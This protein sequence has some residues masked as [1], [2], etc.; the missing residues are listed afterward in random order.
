MQLKKLLC[1]VIILPVC[2]AAQ[3][4]I[5]ADKPQTISQK[6]PIAEQVVL[7][8]VTKTVKDTLV[9]A[10]KQEKTA[11][12]SVKLAM[13]EVNHVIAPVK[14]VAEALFK[15]VPLV[16]ELEYY[17]KNHTQMLEYT[18]NYMRNFSNR[19]NNINRPEKGGRYFAI[20]D[21][22]LEKNSIPKE[23]KY[24]A[25]IE[26][27]LNN[28]AVSPVG[29][30]GPWQFMASTGRLMGLRI[31][32][33]HDERRD[34]AKS[35]Q[36]A[37]KYLTYLYDQLDDW[38]LVVAAYNSG[39]RPVINAINRTGK[40]DYWS[41][42]PYLPKETQNHVLAFI[43]TATIMERLNQYL[44]A[45]LPENFNWTSL[46]VAK[47]KGAVASSTPTNPLLAKFGENELK[48]MALVRIKTP[49]DLDLL[50]N[51]LELDRR[52]LGRWN[53]DYYDYLDT[54]Q[55]GA[56]Y[57]LKIPKEKLDS[58]IEKREILERQSAKL[59]M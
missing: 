9:V 18:K 20:I 29:A 6:S 23:L 48:K 32:G 30:V 17:G 50:A 19:L 22:I 27:A 14:A 24:L 38:L 11:P 36:A 31:N 33:R 8:P 37:C 58:F 34:W 25:V 7:S 53:Y 51:S 4:K 26:S 13:A 52:Q 57:N 49:I 47:G 39:P 28:N 46:N 59:R 45:G 1:A 55:A 35:T 54:Y 2:A 12:G 16:G 56:T 40:S 5:Q 3:Q 43:A 21:K 44:P 10:S 15:P 41:I 42:K